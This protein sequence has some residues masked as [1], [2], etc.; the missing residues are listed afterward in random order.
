MIQHF[1]SVSGG[2]DSQA[3]M[4]VARERMDSHPGFV[5][6]FQFCDVGNENPVTLEHVDYLEQQLG[7]PIERLSAYDVPG[8]IDAE[9]FARKREAIRR[10]WPHELRRTRHTTEC[11]ER[12]AALPKL[13]PGCR[14]SPERAAAL[15][16][17]AMACECPVIVSP[18]VSAQ[19]IEQAVAALQPTGIAFLDMCLLHGRFPSKKAKFCTDEL[20]MRPLLLT[21]APIWD[22][23][24]ITCDWIGERADESKD[25]AKKPQLERERR[26]Q[27]GIRIQYRPIHQ[28]D[29]RWCFDLCKRH[30]L[31]FNPLYLMGAGRVGCWPCINARKA[32]IAL[33]AKITGWKIE[34]L[35]EWERAVSLVSRRDQGGDGEWSTFFSADKVPG[36][37]DD[38]ARASI[39][40]VV[41]WT[42]TTRGGRQ[43]DMIQAIDAD[44]PVACTSEYGLCE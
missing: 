36:D 16:A 25:R 14:H 39:D 2:V 3:V 38:W 12:R 32:E 28:R 27:G 35:R 18:P 43:F 17:W 9:A 42:R 4:C 44:Q 21:R 29:K 10:L 8:L 7:L 34:M 15:S 30:G 40:K 22:A 5:P 31:K 41:A 19:C 11:D 20:K 37:P 13:A 6:R 23:G 24:G 26:P 1:V 33:I